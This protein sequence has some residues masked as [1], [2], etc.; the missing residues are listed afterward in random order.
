[1]A[2]IPSTPQLLRMP[3][4]Q[5]LR[6]PEPRWDV[7][8]PLDWVHGGGWGQRRMVLMSGMG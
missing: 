3:V 2:V 7:P 1:M 5:V 6:S 8:I 4:E